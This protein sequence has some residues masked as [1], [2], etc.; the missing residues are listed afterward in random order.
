MIAITNIAGTR[1]LRVERQGISIDVEL[2]PEE[3]KS[4]SADIH[5]ELIEMDLQA[6]PELLKQWMK[7][8]A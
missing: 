7:H 3:L 1:V 5:A 8:E 6:N 2:S 4:L